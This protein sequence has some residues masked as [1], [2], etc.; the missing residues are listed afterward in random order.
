MTGAIKLVKAGVMMDFHATL[1]GTYVPADDLIAKPSLTL[2]HRLPTDTVAYMAMSTKTKLTGAQ[3][4][5]LMLKSLADS[6]PTTAKEF[7]DGLATMETSVGF[8]LDDL[9]DMVGD[10]AAFGLM[11]DPSFKLDTSDGITDEL[12]KVGLVYVIAVKDDA[13]AKMILAKIHALLETPDVA[14]VAKLTTT[15]DGFEVDPDTVSA[16]PIPNM[17]VKYD[18]KQITVV[19]ASP[20]LTT[21]ALAAIQGGKD[22]LAK[23]SAHELAL[24]AMPK[25]ANF[26]MWLDTG[27]ITSLML[28]GASHVSRHKTGSPLPIDAVR[29][30]GNDRVTSALAVRSAIKSGSW[31]V[32]IDSLNMPAMSLFSV[33]EDLNL[34]SALKGPIFSPKS[35]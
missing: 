4:H 6:D 5:A 23:N 7:S 20:T 27:R 11:L 31:S 14:K 10:E 12:A 26:Y 17:T 18:G 24:S 29:L 15:P 9:I 30:T 8:K 3:I 2:Q 35:L 25:D 21:R 28:D 16:V 19:I 34:G 13:K 22:T 1:S 32:D 33:A